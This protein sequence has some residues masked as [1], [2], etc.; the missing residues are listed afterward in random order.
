[1]AIHD[2]LNNDIAMFKYQQNYPASTVF[3]ISD[4]HD[5]LIMSMYLMN[6]SYGFAYVYVWNF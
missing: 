4:N 1:M 5:Y 2:P 3:T 6:I